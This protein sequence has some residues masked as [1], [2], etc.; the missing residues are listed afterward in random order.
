MRFIII[1]CLL[2]AVITASAQKQKVVRPLSIADT[3]FNTYF[4][5]NTAPVVSGKI[6]NASQQELDTLAVTY[7]LVGPFSQMQSKRTATV[8]R[9]GS[10]SFTLDYPFP[11]QQLFFKLD[12]LFYTA[13]L[14]NKDVFLELDL[15]QLKKKSIDFAG[16]GVS[17]KGSD[18]ALNEWMNQFILF[19]QKRWDHIGYKMYSLSP[20][21]NIFFS[22]LDSLTSKQKVV[23]DTFYGIHSSDYKWIVENE[24]LSAYYSHILDFAFY[25]KLNL[26][27]WEKIK[28]HKTFTISNEGMIFN[29]SL[30]R[31]AL[32]IKA[33]GNKDSF[34]RSM[35]RAYADALRLSLGSTDMSENAKT[36]ASL[37]ADVQTP[38]IKTVL[39]NEHQ[40]LIQH[41]QEVKNMLSHASTG[42]GDSILGTA[43][44]RL[45]FGASLATVSN[46]KA[47]D[48][49]SRLKNK[50]KG[51]AIILDIWATWCAPCLSDLPYSHKLHDAASALPVEFVYL[52]SSKSSS[53]EKWKNKVIELKQPGTHIFMDEK[54]TS[55]LMAMFNKGGYPSYICLDRS[56]QLSSKLAIN[57]MNSV[58][59]ADINKLVD[60]TP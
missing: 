24:R 32:F 47:T 23:Y 50:F 17:F 25:N 34:A 36:L 40:L 54:L 41:L 19:R 35:G 7:T 45:P 11:Y 14:V 20:N 15:A 49:I 33:S 4:Y 31:Y 30:L 1:L 27:M 42:T 58:T 2:T 57:F 29:H 16:K 21:K 28:A 12:T 52:C 3:T 59:L 13:V 60:S 38:W 53:V 37:K 26:P 48:F 46:M 56:G 22:Q 55:E 5:K 9:D 6:I 43:F 8:N 44:T 18:G 39:E 51:K 10:F